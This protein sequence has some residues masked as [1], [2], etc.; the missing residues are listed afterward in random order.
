M[1]GL[2][3]ATSRTQFKPAFR[4]KAVLE[5]VKEQKA[6]ASIDKYARFLENHVS[7]FV[8][9]KMVMAKDNTRLRGC[10]LKLTFK[11]I[12]LT[13]GSSNIVR[14]LK[15]GVYEGDHYENRRYRAWKNGRPYC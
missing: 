9:L 1:K 12:A 3:V 6:R 4:L 8:F 15:R 11:T 10:Q 14:C 7:F 13:L 2:E 5:G